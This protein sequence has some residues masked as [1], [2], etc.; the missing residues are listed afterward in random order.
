[1]TSTWCDTAEDNSYS[2]KRAKNVHESKFE[3]D[4]AGSITDC[5]EELKLQKIELMRQWHSIEVVMTV[6]RTLIGD[7][8]PH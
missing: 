2:W 6:D 1:M 3:E 4:G 5:D 7:L 8:E